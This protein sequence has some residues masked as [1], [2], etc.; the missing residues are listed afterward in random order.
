MPRRKKL[1]LPDGYTITPEELTNIVHEN[2]PQWQKA[3]KQKRPY[4]SQTMCAR[5]S[6]LNALQNEHW[7]ERDPAMNFYATSGNSMEDAINKIFG[8]AGIFIK[9]NWKMPPE[10]FEDKF[11]VGGKIDSMLW[12]NEGTNLCFLELKCISNVEA[13]NK[14]RIPQLQ[15]DVLLQGGE[16]VFAIE[17]NEEHAFI[18]DSEGDITSILLGGQYEDENGE[19]VHVEGYKVIP[20][21]AQKPKVSYLGQAE[22]YSA[23]TGINNGFICMVSRGVVDNWN[24]DSKNNISHAFF[25]IDISPDNLTKRV[26]SVIYTIKCRDAGYVAQKPKGIK[27][28][29]CSGAFCPFIDEC[30]GNENFGLQHVPTTQ[31]NSWKVEA[32][33]IAAKYIEN[34]PQRYETVLELMRKIPVQKS[35]KKN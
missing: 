6:S 1:V 29:H 34:R 35:K 25:P 5:M 19:M 24:F 7:V 15:T 9:D 12:V 14:I 31:S 16:L 33:E 27:K 4:A 13:Q 2:T 28:S 10:L 17:N 20:T 30:W 32:M 8:R 26:A 3:Y 11:D 21:V 18:R 23:V 22:L